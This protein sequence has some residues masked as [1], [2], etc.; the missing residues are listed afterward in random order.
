MNADHTPTSQAILDACWSA[1]G[2]D[3]R[4][5]LLSTVASGFD[6]FL[7]ANE[8]YGSLVQALVRGKTVEALAHYP[9]HDVVDRDSGS[10]YFYHCHREVD[11]EHGHLHVF[12]HADSLGRRHRRRGKRR[13]WAPSHLFAIRL[14]AQG[15]PLAL[16]TTNRWVTGGHWFDAPTTEAF[17]DRFK[18]AASGSFAQVNAWLES[19]I[20]FY[21]PLILPLLLERDERLRQLA[22]G[23][24]LAAAQK[25]KR[26]EVLSEQL[27]DWEKDLEAFEVICASDAV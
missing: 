13:T 12:W 1:L 22:R 7:S 5:A 24:G 17:L 27:I 2:P 6:A 16:F 21:R 3:G 26:I 11:G 10:Q 15:K 23:R 18:L 14:D 4:R 9:P 8:A 25:L 20:R 19:F